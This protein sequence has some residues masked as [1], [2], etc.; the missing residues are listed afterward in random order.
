[1]SDEWR[2]VLLNQLSK[3]LPTLQQDPA[4]ACTL[5]SAL[6]RA[7]NFDFGKVMSIEPKVDFLTGLS[8]SSM[9]INLVTLELL[10]KANC[11]TSD[12]GIVASMPEVVQALVRLWLCAQEVAVH[13]KAQS[14]LEQFLI[15]SQSNELMWRRILGDKDI[16]GSIFSLCSLETL[17][18]DGQPNKNDKTIAQGRLLAL[19]AK[20]DSQ[21]VRISQCPEVE[22]RY[23]ADNLL[24]FAVLRM[25]DY[26]GDVLMHMTLIQFFT[27]WLREGAK[28]MRTSDNPS[29]SVPTTS[30]A[31]DYLLAQGL[32]SRTVSYF[33]EPSSLDPWDARNLYSQA[34]EYLGTYFTIYVDY[35]LG[36]G[37]GILKS[38]LSCISEVLDKTSPGLF[39]SSPPTTELAV[40]VRVPRVALLLRDFASPSLL[41]QIPIQPPSALGFDV[42]ANLFDGLHPRAGTKSAARALYFLY[43]KQRPGF[44]AHVIK[45]AETLALKD[46]AVAAGRVVLSVVNAEWEPMERVIPSSQLDESMFRLRSEQE[47]ADVCGFRSLAPSGF[48]AILA[49][50]AL[51]TVMPW[52]LQPAQKSTDLGIGGKGDVEGAANSVAEVKYDALQSLYKKLEQHSMAHGA[53]PAWQDILAQMRKRLTQG[54]WG[55]ISGVGGSIA[56]SQR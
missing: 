8:A 53:D 21:E 1:M 50:P 31:L 16:Y 24:D 37:R 17:G 44:W 33:T 23:G 12:V 29:A 15:G 3:L 40:L 11:S 20:L 2:I 7:E 34:A 39:I 32:H 49:S 25:V 27:E 14:L 46:A 26:K 43:T 30:S 42:L 28:K 51:E 52:L 13:Q 54:R 18:L 55:G 41:F 6:I 36:P 4:P 10:E 22:E 38:T 5:T 35:A 47:L 56:T 48:L 9:P 45:S 19:L